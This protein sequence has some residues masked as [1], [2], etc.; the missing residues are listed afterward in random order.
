MISL[1]LI[2]FLGI[3]TQSAQASEMIWSDLEPR[4]FDAKVL[5]QLGIEEGKLN[6]V[7]EAVKNG[8]KLNAPSGVGHTAVSS[9][10]NYGQPHIVKY[11]T[12][13]IYDKDKAQSLARALSEYSFNAPE[14]LTEKK[15]RA[16]YAALRVLVRLTRN[17]LNTMNLTQKGGALVPAIATQDAPVVELL[18]RYGASPDVSGDFTPLQDALK[19]GNRDI[20]NLLI[21]YGADVSQLSEDEHAQLSKIISS[22]ERE[23]DNNYMFVLAQADREYRGNEHVTIR[24]KLSQDLGINIWEFLYKP[25]AEVRAVLSKLGVREWVLLSLIS[26]RYRELIEKYT[27]TLKTL[28]RSMCTGSIAD[29]DTLNSEYGIKEV[30]RAAIIELLESLFVNVSSLDL[31]GKFIEYNK[32]KDFADTLQA[33]KSCTQLI[34]QDTNIS[35][36]QELK[37]IA[38]LFKNLCQLNVSNTCIGKRA[39]DFIATI[40]SLRY[41]NAARNPCLDAVAL[42]RFAPLVNLQVLDVSECCL[43]GQELDAI[44]EVLPQL[45]RLNIANNRA[46]SITLDNLKRL[47]NLKNLVEF[48]CSDNS[49]GFEGILVLLETLRR[50]MPCI[51]YFWG[52]NNKILQSR[53]EIFSRLVLSEAKRQRVELQRATRVLFALADLDTLEV[54]N[55]SGNSFLYIVIP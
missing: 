18:L 16:R 30:T 52:V 41:L 20:V 26:P 54:S 12:R 39:C 21:L 10:V 45:V 24:E 3:S 55:I 19:M 37:I 44:S 9:A 27:H 11:L 51:K 50:N 4:G 34:I 35:R 31:T 43:R 29:C 2:L 6:F 8:I 1:L 40:N 17:Y 25:E 15:K 47:G 53:A 38:S 13:R 14:N 7:K 5:L 42:K 49:L 32:E 28:E 22:R 46:D 36:P 48:N 23:Y 33:F